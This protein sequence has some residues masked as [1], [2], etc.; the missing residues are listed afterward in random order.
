MSFFE[1]MI[2]EVNLFGLGADPIA[3]AFAI[4]VALFI[5]QD[6]IKGKGMDK[7]KYTNAVAIFI[8]TYAAM[9]AAEV[10]TLLQLY[11]PILVIGV[12]GIIL[13][14]KIKG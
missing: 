4:A 6:E 3:I 10:A 1:E 12:V 9:F 13:G 7:P 14:E 8:I 5:C 11:I 2:A